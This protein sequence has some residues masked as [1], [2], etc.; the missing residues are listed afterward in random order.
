MVVGAGALLGRCPEQ[1]TGLNVQGYLHQGLVFG[2]FGFRCLGR[3]GLGVWVVRG[4]GFTAS[5]T[6][7]STTREQGRGR[8]GATRPLRNTNKRGCAH[9]CAT[10]VSPLASM[11]C[12][13]WNMHSSGDA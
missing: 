6:H 3:S 9:H 8:R 7:K 4:L 13:A 12:M 1:H 11:A 10:T 2:S 5:V